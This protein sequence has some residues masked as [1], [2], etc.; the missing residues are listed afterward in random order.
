MKE[1]K[2]LF[3][4]STNTY[5]LFFLSPIN[6]EPFLGIFSMLLYKIFANGSQALN[7]LIF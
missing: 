1:R 6:T 4:K 3:Q 5:G 2:I 7:Y